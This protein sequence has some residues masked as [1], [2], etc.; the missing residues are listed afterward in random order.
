VAQK[1][2]QSYP[3]S[4]N[5]DGQTS[6][7]RALVRHGADGRQAIAGVLGAAAEDIRV[8]G[9]RSPAPTV[10]VSERLQCTP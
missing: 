5:L 3:S 7:S 1:G 9:D 10:A 8:R 2:E 6:W 4:P